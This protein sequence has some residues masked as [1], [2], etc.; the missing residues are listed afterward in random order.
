ML[1]LATV[2]DAHWNGLKVVTKSY[3]KPDQRDRIIEALGPLG[4]QLPSVDEETLSRYYKYLT[5]RLSFPFTACYP[6][7]TTSLEERQHRC[8]VLELLDPIN[9]ICDEFDGIFCKTRKGKYQINLP[10]VE[11]KI[12]QNSPNFQLIEDYWFWFWN[13][14]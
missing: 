13:W 8:T 12:P 10:L 4:E 5:A 3:R 11:L 6:E 14:R 1:L 2:A 7:P 9:D